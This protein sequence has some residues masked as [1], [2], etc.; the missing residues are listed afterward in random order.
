MADRIKVPLECLP[1]QVKPKQPSRN[2]TTILYN[3]DE[4]WI[5]ILVVS[6]DL[7]MKEGDKGTYCAVLQHTF[8]FEEKLIIAFIDLSLKDLNIHVFET[9]R[10]KIR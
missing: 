7:P 5:T 2:R 1:E 3:R 10:N 8:T 9:K 4:N 6:Q